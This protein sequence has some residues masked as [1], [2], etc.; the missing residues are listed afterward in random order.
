MTGPLL[1]VKEVCDLLKV[2]P[3][4]VYRHSVE[5]GGVKVGRHLRYRK[6]GSPVRLIPVV[7]PTEQG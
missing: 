4:F 7:G 6:S 2:G 3:T 5:L 1:D